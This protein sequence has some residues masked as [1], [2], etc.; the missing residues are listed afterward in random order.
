MELET[1]RKNI[2]PIQKNIDKVKELIN[3]GKRVV[4]ISDMY[5]NAQQI[6][7]ILVP[8]DKIFEDIKLY[9][10]VEY[11]K[12]KYNGELYEYV[13]ELE[14]IEYNNWVHNGDNSFSDIKIA[15][16]K[17]IKANWL[18]FEDLMPYENACLFANI[19]NYYYQGLIGCA[20]ATRALSEDKSNVYN[21]GVSFA[22]PILFNYVNWLIG[23]ALNKNIKTL[24]FIARDGFVLKEIADVIISK[25]NLNINTKYIYGSRKAWRIPD[26]KTVDS[27]I[28][29]IFSEYC[30]LFNLNFIAERFGISPEKFSKFVDKSKYKGKFKSKQIRNLK[31]ELLNNSKFKNYIIKL[32]KSKKEKIQRYFEQNLDFSQD[33]IVFVDINGSGRTQDIISNIIS[34]ISPNKKIIGYY[35]HLEFNVEQKEESLKL[36]YIPTVSYHNSC[37]ELFCRTMHGQT[38]GYEQKDGRVIPVFEDGYNSKMLEKWGYFQYIKGLQDYTSRVIDFEYKNNLSLCSYNVYIDYFK[39]FLYNLDK[40]TANII[41]TIPYSSIGYE[42]MLQE[43]APKYNFIDFLKILLGI[44]KFNQLGFISVAR[45]GKMAEKAYAFKA[46]Y[47]NLRKFLLHV[48]VNRKQKIFYIRILGIKISFNSIFR[49]KAHG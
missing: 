42:K 1:E 8:I 12:A 27:Y 30:S 2:V 20:K 43:C 36:P 33:E 49:G 7:S 19:D 35:F 17:G 22:G 37:I 4:L 15:K 11:N 31:N 47:G 48:Q 3:E 39:Y 44:D 26:D 28:E 18:K 25:R 14:Q 40:D 13:R 24:H 10:S 46:K 9:V 32:N 29:Y 5:L 6:R 38:L 16:E 23:Q 34:E 45:S 21:L 41:G